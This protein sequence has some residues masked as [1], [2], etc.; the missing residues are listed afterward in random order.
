[1]R[2]EREKEEG[3]RDEEALKEGGRGRRMEDEGKKDL[4]EIKGRTG[5]VRK[6]RRGR[7]RKGREMVEDG[8]ER[9]LIVAPPPE[10]VSTSSC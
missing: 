9:L 6:E 7:E 5:P 10:M 1:M 2:G 3:K 4:K 8:K